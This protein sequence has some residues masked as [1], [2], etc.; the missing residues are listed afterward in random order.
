ME[1]AKY[2]FDINRDYKMQFETYL[3]VLIKSLRESDSGAI[4]NRGMYMRQK[5]NRLQTLMWGRWESDL[6][7]NNL[8][9]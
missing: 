2:T 8:N 7:R 1:Q 9:D 3:N 6:N 4:I 5:L